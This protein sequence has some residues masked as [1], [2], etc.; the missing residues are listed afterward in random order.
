VPYHLPCSVKNQIVVTD[1]QRVTLWNTPQI[2]IPS[3]WGRRE[4]LI[5][6]R[7]FWQ[8]LPW[9]V[10]DT[11][12]SPNAQTSRM[13]S[14]FNIKSIPFGKHDKIYHVISIVANTTLLLQSCADLQCVVRS[15]KHT[16]WCRVCSLF[17]K[18]GRIFGVRTRCNLNGKSQ[19]IN[20]PWGFIKQSFLSGR[21]NCCG[22]KCFI[23]YSGW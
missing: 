9:L 16:C 5:V 11:H 13:W 2:R 17:K 18:A 19:A 1:G 8:S 20:W 6:H 14:I 10:T 21:A 22:Y 15:S 4:R 3:W 12:R 7:N 23:N